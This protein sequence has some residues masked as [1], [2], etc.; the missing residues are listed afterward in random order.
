VLRRRIGGAVFVATRNSWH[1]NRI[2]VN[3]AGCA[4][5]TMRLNPRLSFLLAVVQYLY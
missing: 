5:E 3:R 1:G 4:R 2:T